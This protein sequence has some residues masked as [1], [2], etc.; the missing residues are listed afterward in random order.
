MRRHDHGLGSRIIIGETTSFLEEKQLTDKMDLARSVYMEAF[1][2]GDKERVL[3][4][5]EMLNEAQND[6][7][8][9][10]S[11]KSHRGP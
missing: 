10:S 11:A 3:Q 2:E 5:Q 6:L 4:A 8:D 1:E 7:K 9:V